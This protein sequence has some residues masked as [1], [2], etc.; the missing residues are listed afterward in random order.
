M[1]DDELDIKLRS[2]AEVATRCIIL[3]ALL[4][5][6]LIESIGSMNQTDDSDGE[7]FDIRHW[8]IAEG[9]WAKS[10]PHEAAIFS[11]PFG[12]LSE[13]E[14]AF[15]SSQAEGL[16]TLSWSLSL[17][18]ELSPDNH[19]DLKPVF[20]MIPSPWDKTSAWVLRAHLRDED[21][22]A[23]ER[24]RVEIH[25]WRIRAESL[26]RA[27]SGRERAELAATIA[28]VAA[29]AESAGLIEID[30]DRGRSIGAAP[31]GTQSNEQLDQLGSFAEHRLRALNWVCGFGN[32]WDEVPLDV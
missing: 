6:L 11:T 15:I 28:R 30:S 16:A 29:E 5:R 4:R 21:Q 9:V 17:S 25:E 18:E 31:F 32:S 19:D 23:R 3:A 12:D 10:T 27:A 7:I 8:L 2:S 26:Y 20:N 14:I 24:E 13:A 22:L 1:A